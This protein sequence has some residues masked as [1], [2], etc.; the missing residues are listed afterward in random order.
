VF[1]R[2]STRRERP[3]TETSLE[4]FSLGIAETRQV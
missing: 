1:C 3:L 2:Y 4:K